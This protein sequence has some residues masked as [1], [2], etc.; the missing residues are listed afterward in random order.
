MKLKL[1]SHPK[2]GDRERERERERERVHQ[3][4]ETDRLTRARD[5][6]CAEPSRTRPPSYV[7]VTVVSRFVGDVA[8]EVE[9]L[10]CDAVGTTESFPLRHHR[11]P[12]TKSTRR[13]R[14]LNKKIKGN[15]QTFR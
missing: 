7:P 2:A 12:V 9:T 11:E 5:F 13:E 15:V 6:R 1:P 4:T 3:A 8:V 14:G 10:P